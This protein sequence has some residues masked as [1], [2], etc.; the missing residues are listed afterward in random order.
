[1]RYRRKR[2]K[3]NLLEADEIPKDTILAN[4]LFM[5]RYGRGRIGLRFYD[6]K[7][8]DTEYGEVLMDSSHIFAISRKPIL[9]KKDRVQNWEHITTNLMSAAIKFLEKLSIEEFEI[10]TEHDAPLI[11]KA[12][13]KEERKE[14]IYISIAPRVED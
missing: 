14:E 12:H 1:M 13:R 7:D 10:I 2:E 3:I 8:M 11:I 4:L 6:N 5:D 9:G